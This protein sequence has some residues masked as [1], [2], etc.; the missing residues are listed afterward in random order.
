MNF[1]VD[2]LLFAELAGYT[3]TGQYAIKFEASAARYQRVAYHPTGVTG[4]Y[5]VGGGLMDRPIVLTGRWIEADLD[6]LEAAVELFRESQ[7][8]DKPVS[9]IGPDAVT[10]LRC[11]MQTSR[12]IREPRHCSVGVFKDVEFSFTQYG[13][14]E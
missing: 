6:A 12:T 13:G 11:F 8:E 7:L 14:V 9:I 4:S 5:T 1:T 10:Y 2:G 3:V